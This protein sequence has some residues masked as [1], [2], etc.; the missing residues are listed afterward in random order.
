MKCLIS[1]K[2]HKCPLGNTFIECPEKCDGCKYNDVALDD[3]YAGRD[4]FITSRY[5]GYELGS[6]GP[7][8]LFPEK[9]C[10]QEICKMAEALV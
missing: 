4:G 8:E 5:M 1:L 10:P 9:E 2:D 6:F 7:Q 3:C